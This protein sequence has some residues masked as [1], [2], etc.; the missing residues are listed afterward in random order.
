MQMY[1]FAREASCTASLKSSSA[2]LEAE[3]V[4]QRFLLGRLGA[5]SA[6]WAGV[7]AEV[8]ALLDCLSA[9]G[10]ALLDATLGG[11]AGCG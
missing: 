5:V 8:F 6:A 10:A 2:F 11:M 3:T 7:A 1:A 9:A 4:S